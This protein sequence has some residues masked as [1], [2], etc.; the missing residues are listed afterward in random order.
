MLSAHCSCSAGAGSTV[1]EPQGRKKQRQPGKGGPAMR[2]LDAR[3][4]SGSVLKA[5]DDSKQEGDRIRLL[6][7][8]VLSAV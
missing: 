1:E 5:V 4:V 6:V 3:R 2:G 8:K 7:K